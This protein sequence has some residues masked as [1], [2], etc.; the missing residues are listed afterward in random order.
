[1]AR[2]I[3]GKVVEAPAVAAAPPPPQFPRAE[4][5]LTAEGLSGLTRSFWAKSGK[6]NPTD[7]LSVP[8]HLMD[9]ADVAGRLFDSYL[10]EH[11]R[12]LMA[13]VWGGDQAKARTSLVFLAGVHDVGKAS[14]PFCCQHGPLADFVR[15][16]GVRVPQR[17]DVP[18]RGN[19]PHGF[20]SRFALVDAI[21]E[22]G[23]DRDC[24]DQWAAIIGV[25]HGRYPDGTQVGRARR[26]YKGELGRPQK[27][28][29]WEQSR[30]EL[31]EWMARRSGFP[32][33]SPAPTALPELSIAV[34]SAYASAVVIADWIASNE[35]Y[36]PLRPQAGREWEL[37]ADEQWER[38]ERGWESADMPRPMTVPATAGGSPES[39][40]RHR[41]GWGL[42]ITPTDAQIAA[43]RLAEEADPDLMIVEAP[44]GSGKTELAFAVAERMVRSRGLQ[45]VF[46]G[47]PTQATTNA[48][49]ER[50]TKWL[51]NLLGDSPQRL[52][53]HLAHGKNDLNDAFVALLDRDRG[54][55]VQVH[56][57]EEGD[58]GEDY[59]SLRASTWMAGR[60][61]ATLSPVVIGTI[62]QVLLTAL[63][64]RHVLV[65][66]LGLMGKA[67]ILDEVHA[68]DTY[69]GT[70]LKAALTWLGM[71][72]I[73]VVLLSATLPAERRIELAEAYRRGRCRR[74]VDDS[75]RLDGNIGYPVLT[76]VSRG[77]QE[78]D[79]HVV[80]GGG[81][82][83]RRT[84]LPLV[85]QS[86]QDL[87]PVLDEA[88]AEGGCAVV[89]RN[90]VK[91]AQATYDALAPHFGADGVTLLHSRFIA[92]DR[93][94]RD[95]RML[96][97]FG[98]DSAA[99]PRR[100][101]V[102]ATQVIE[103]SLDVDFDVMVT[104][105]APMDLVL[106]RIGRLHRHP[107]RERPAPLR[108]ARCHVMVADTGPAPWA[109]S[110]GTDVVYER[111]HVLRALG[112][113][114]DRGRIGVERPGDYAELTQLAY[115][116]EAVGP[117]TW[118][119]AL[120]E[121]E[122]ETEGHTQDAT[123]R[124]EEWCLSDDSLQEW[125]VEQFDFAFMG[126]SITGDDG[127][128]KGGQ[129]AAQ[130]AVRDSEDQIPVLL[131]AVDPGMGCVPIKPP[132]RVDADGETIPI[133]VSTWPSPGLVREM[134]TWSVSLP[135]WPFRET[136]K[137]IDEAV[138]AVACA[139]WNDEATRDWECLEHPLL[140]GELVLAMHKTDEGST[141][142]ERDLLG[143]HLVYTQER[144]LE[145]QG[146]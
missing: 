41:F 21:V 138:D 1:M 56:D 133:D 50:A 136:G 45:G 16:H 144:G 8:Q 39:Y 12:A 146:R 11:H 64:S 115:S 112:V 26:A 58:S 65:R 51:T 85:A 87:V 78:V 24:A 10:S 15:A 33:K 139:I 42:A 130:A 22:G 141:R 88:L 74:E 117:A 99:R 105:P 132:W 126:N 113:L 91:D 37:T 4:P 29:R 36:F 95:E 71:Y 79:I 40:Y 101:V 128:P 17:R 47:L 110:G 97:L 31:I 59:S 55:P 66:H 19:L 125:T 60:W 38:A 90:T 81:P 48:M 120:Q 70:Y 93:V 34:A 119:G 62:D 86:P 131:V 43:V 28:P 124:A 103:Q 68:A 118:A 35:D 46:I 54:Y 57:E 76:T 14:L 32:L 84:I 6:R 143:C 18:D 109:Y 7:W 63:K 83:A 123:R 73:P 30:Q 75:A 52:G 96:R 121:A 13:S 9:A 108:E 94:E 127:A 106:Q 20:A 5:G 100:H 2:K 72:G 82:E 69:M 89:I 114:A 80:G 135:P 140:R 61:R 25:H 27:E 104:D 102:V 98:K 134:R 116:D 122:R 67:V 77:G 137:A 145:V 107:G 23:G 3:D 44:P 53:I 111:S 129:I 92:S 142:L 49:F